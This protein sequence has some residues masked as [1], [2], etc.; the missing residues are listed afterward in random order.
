MPDYFYKMYEKGGFVVFLFLER[1]SQAANLL[2][3]NTKIKDKWPYQ[4]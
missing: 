3:Q 4:L 2:S 1:K